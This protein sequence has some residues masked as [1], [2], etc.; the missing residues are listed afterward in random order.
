MQVNNK[1]QIRLKEEEGGKVAL[2]QSQQTSLKLNATSAIGMAIINLN[3]E[4]IYLKQR[5]KNLILQK[6]KK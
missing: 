3:V 4:L 2:I 1:F 5:G 6:K